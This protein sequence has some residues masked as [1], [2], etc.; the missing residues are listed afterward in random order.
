MDHVE[1]FTVG[2][3]NCAESALAGVLG[4]RDCLDAAA[5]FGGGM[6]RSG[7]VCGALTGA[8][9]GIGL[10][11]KVRDRDAVHD[12]AALQDLVAELLDQ[13]GQQFGS[14]LC[15]DLTAYDLADAAGRKLFA[16]EDDG[17]KRCVDYVREAVAVARRLLDEAGEGPEPR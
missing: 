14:T 11:M 16:T 9:M 8:I 3:Y 2:G 10:A 12:Y 4:R 1:M 7:S 15:R 17:R 13:F 5:G 6:G